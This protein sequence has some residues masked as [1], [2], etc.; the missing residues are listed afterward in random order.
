MKETFI[1]ASDNVYVYISLSNILSTTIHECYIY[2]YPLFIIQ[3][4][5]LYSRDML[6]SM[7]TAYLLLR[8]MSVSK[9]MHAVNLVWVYLKFS[10]RNQCH[11]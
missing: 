9:K 6:V 1:Q 3:R 8:K 7:E 2:H 10:P 5:C 11:L 4:V